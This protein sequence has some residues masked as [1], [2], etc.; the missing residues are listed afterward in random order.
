MQ[1]TLLSILGLALLGALHA[2]NSIPVQ[3]DFQQDKVIEPGQPCCVGQGCVGCSS[4]QKC[5]L[6]GV[7]VGWG[8]Y[9]PGNREKGAPIAS[10]AQHWSPTKLGD[11]LC[12]W[13]LQGAPRGV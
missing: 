12:C 6:R 8:P 4:P 11:G 5:A 3:A 9:C 10:S 2:Q 7:L 13:V 1:A